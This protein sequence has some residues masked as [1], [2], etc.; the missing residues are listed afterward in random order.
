MRCTSTALTTYATTRPYLTVRQLDFHPVPLWPILVCDW[1]FISRRCPII[2][3][4]QCIL[5][6]YCRC[7]ASPA[8]LAMIINI[9]PSIY[10][11]LLWIRH[12]TLHVITKLINIIN[13]HISIQGGNSTHIHRIFRLD[14]LALAHWGVQLTS[15]SK[16]TK[17]FWCRDRPQSSVSR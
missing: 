15:L 1:K 2:Q 5:Q 13:I 10:C 3:G 12:K 7:F 11:R 17:I 6:I 14:W 16:I 9:T 8:L 4:M